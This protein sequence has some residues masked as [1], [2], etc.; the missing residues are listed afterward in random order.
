MAARP[1]RP[2]PA[3]GA[4][5][6]HKLERILEAKDVRAAP[7]PPRSNR[8]DADHLPSCHL[9]GHPDVHGVLPSSHTT[10]RILCCR[11]ASTQHFVCNRS[12]AIST[13]PMPWRAGAF[14]WKPNAPRGMVTIPESRVVHHVSSAMMHLPRCKSTEVLLCSKLSY[15]EGSF[16]TRPHLW[17][18]GGGMPRWLDLDIRMLLEGL[19]PLACRAWYCLSTHRATQR[20][21]MLGA[22]SAPRHETRP[23]HRHHASTTSASQDA[24]CKRGHV[25]APF[26]P[27]AR[28][29]RIAEGNCVWSVTRAILGFLLRVRP[30][31]H[32]GRECWCRVARTSSSC[33]EELNSHVN[34]DVACHPAR[35]IDRPCGTAA[36]LRRSTRCKEL[37]SR[38]VHAA[39]SSACSA[40]GTL[41]A[42]STVA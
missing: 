12:Q 8:A 10:A 3:T 16:A 5:I 22:L 7:H 23:A 31:A 14:D 4:R 33:S 41:N 42:A 27:S 40:H 36:T 28:P 37:A 35:I 17:A 19:A 29:Q 34:A 25:L 18:V 11:H 15:H 39:R 13:L 32:C 38:P 21:L 6:Q 30:P 9:Q 2:R 1:C 20:H 26:A 24:L